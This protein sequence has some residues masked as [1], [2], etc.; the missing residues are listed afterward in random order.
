LTREAGT[1][2]LANDTQPEFQLL[3]EADRADMEVY[4]D[5]LKLVLPILGFDLFKRTAAGIA[6][7]ARSDDGTIFTFTPVGAAATARETDD[8][9]VV[10]ASSTARKGGTETFQTGYRALRDDLVRDG[11]LI[12]GPS[13]DLYLFAADIAFAS[14]S[15]AASVVA[16][17]SAAGPR[18]W[19]VKGTGQLYRDW[20]AAK[21][22]SN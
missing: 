5:Q 22:D 18:E 15:A 21:L 1:V 16:A 8:G 2:S 20:R 19:K 14:P 12:N 7:A 13:N 6:A 9:F 10:L 4:I 11:R 17:R 3:P